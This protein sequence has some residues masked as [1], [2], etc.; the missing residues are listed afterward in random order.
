D[1]LLV[2]KA[3]FP[4]DKVCGD[5]FSASS[6][7]VLERVRALEVIERMNPFRIDGVTVSSPNGTIASAKTPSVKGLRDYGYVI[8]RKD[9]DYQLL[10]FV[11]EVPRVKVLESFSVKDLVYDESNVCGVRSDDETYLG[12]VII[13]ADGV[14][15]TIAK[16]LSMRNDNPKHRALAVRAYFENIENLNHYIEIHYE[17][18]ILPAYG[19]IFPTSEHSANVGIGVGTRFTDTKEI[20]TL[21][22]RFLERNSYARKKLKNAHM[23]ENSFKGC[24]LTF[25]SFPSKR[26][27][28]NVLLIGDAASFI[29]VLTGEGIYYA[30]R[31][32]ELAAQA[33]DETLHRS[34]NIEGVATLYEKLWMKEFRWKEFYAGYLLQS[35]LNNK[36]IVN[37]NISRAS[38]R[39]K[40]AE[41]LA[42]V[43]AHKLPK[44]KLFFNV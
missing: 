33:M 2:D 32:G 19:W 42:G 5:G 34:N 15:S 7:A 21:F 1:V 29:D 38:K 24:P 26:S 22:Y 6:L 37:F 12:K 9:F 39:V 40:N 3:E 13:G 43:I 28:R 23:I 17:E 31:S 41:T 25:G 4:R 20:K 44:W 10:Q 16:K 8:P 27:Y 30:L 35:L 36:H 14:H 11:K 18:S